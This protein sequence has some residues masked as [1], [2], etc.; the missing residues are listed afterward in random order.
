MNQLEYSRGHKYHILPHICQ[1]QEHNHV[2]FQKEDIERH[3]KDHFKSLFS[4]GF[5][6]QDN[7]LIKETIPFLVKDSTNTLLTNIPS[8][9]EIHQANL[10]LNSDA[11]IRSDGFGAFFYQKHWEIIKVDVINFISQLFLHDWIMPHNNLNTLIMIPK[12]KEADNVNQYMYIALTCVSLHN[13]HTRISL[14]VS[15]SINLNIS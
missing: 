2:I 3:V 1:N 7:G 13:T 11:S 5:M 4:Q 14:L 9:E 10:N 8:E 12:C 6:V 15:S